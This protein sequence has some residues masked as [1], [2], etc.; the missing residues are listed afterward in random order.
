MSL[1]RANDPEFFASYISM[2]R[3]D[4]QIDTLVNRKRE[5]SQRKL[6]NISTTSGAKNKSTSK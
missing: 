1:D 3:T 2:L 6:H 4:S 5:V